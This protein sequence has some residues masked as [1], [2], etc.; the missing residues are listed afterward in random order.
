MELWSQKPTVAAAVT[1]VGREME[2]VEGKDG[3]VIGEKSV[4]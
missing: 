2:P 4:D 3:E 1:G